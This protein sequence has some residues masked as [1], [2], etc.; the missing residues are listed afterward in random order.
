LISSQSWDS[1]SLSAS[2][3]SVVTRSTEFIII[4]FR[5]CISCLSS[6]YLKMSQSPTLDDWNRRQLDLS[7]RANASLNH[8]CRLL[9]SSDPTSSPG[10]R[11]KIEKEF[12]VIASAFGLL[13]RILMLG[14]VLPSLHSTFHDA[15]Q[16][17]MAC[18]DVALKAFDRP[19]DRWVTARFYFDEFDTVKAKAEFSCRRMFY[20]LSG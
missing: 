9:N 7:L 5:D 13:D 16:S 20:P 1:I 18:V 10:Y 6:M 4:S 14:L 2:R 8:L 3:L 11:R 17:C 12:P 15:V 19:Q